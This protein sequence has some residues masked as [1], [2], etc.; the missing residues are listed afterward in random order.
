VVKRI[1]FLLIGLVGVVCSV[2]CAQ[3]SDSFD[4]DGGS[5][6]NGGASGSTTAGSGGA[7]SGASTSGSTT[8]SGTGTATGAGGGGGEGGGGNECGANQHSCGGIC[9]GN[10]PQTGCFTSSTCT[11]CTA[12]QN[13]S[14]ICS[15]DGECDFTCAAGYQQN[16]NTCSCAQQ[17][18]SNADCPAGETC[19]GGV[20]S[21]PPCDMNACIAQCIIMGCVGVCMGDCVCL[22]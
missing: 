20:C 12:P 9:T 21:G 5:N 3:G 17:C 10:T 2:G 8:S 14:S 7:T 19:G 18:C 6:G 11:A 22:C 4:G 16:G 13:G 1:G 15:I